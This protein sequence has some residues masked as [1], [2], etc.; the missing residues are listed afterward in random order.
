MRRRLVPLIRGGAPSSGNALG[1]PSFKASY[2]PGFVYWEDFTNGASTSETQG[3]GGAQWWV[4]RAGGAETA[5]ASALLP[6]GSMQLAGALDGDRITL[7]QNPRDTTGASIING[8]HAAPPFLLATRIRISAV[9]SCVAAAG[10]TTVGSL[11]TPGF[12]VTGHGGAFA[13][14][15]FYFNGTDL[16]ADFLNNGA[17][18]T[19]HILQAAPAAGTLYKCEAVVTPTPWGDYAVDWYLNGALIASDTGL[20]D[21]ASG[22]GW[23]PVMEL[24]QSV[25]A[26]RTFTVDYLYATQKLTAAR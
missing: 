9:A 20:G 4:Q 12:T 21:G 18:N 2:N 17:V 6:S 15:V 25:A 10:F 13:G 23:G 3:I 5:G 14:V 24:S 22:G 26:A 19:T 11:F 7:R 8:G 1:V 16:M